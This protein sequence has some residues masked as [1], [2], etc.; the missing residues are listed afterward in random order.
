MILNRSLKGRWHY[1]AN[2]R[3]FI[4]ERLA[5]RGFF[6]NNRQMI[7]SSSW[8]CIPRLCRILCS[9]ADL[10]TLNLLNWKLRLTQDVPQLFRSCPKLTELHLKIDGRQRLKMNEE[11][12]NELRPGFQRLRLFELEWGINS[13]PV[14]E[15]IFT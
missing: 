10:E 2:S 3:L 7:V 5:A 1:L 12:K 15:E 11:I 4:L 8:P 14:V 13:L 9:M 6:K